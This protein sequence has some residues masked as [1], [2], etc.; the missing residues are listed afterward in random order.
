MTVQH[1]GQKGQLGHTTI[2]WQDS[3]GGGRRV[4]HNNYYSRT[5]QTLLQSPVITKT[6][7][8]IAS[9]CTQ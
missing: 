2:C 4:N 5:Q 7:I 6:Q 8:I 1:F 9:F 3:E